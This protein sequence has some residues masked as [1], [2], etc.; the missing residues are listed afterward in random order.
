MLAVADH[1]IDSFNS[2]SLEFGCMDGLNTFLLLGGRL[3]KSF[4]VFKETRW[5]VDSHLEATLKDDYYD[6]YDDDVK[7]LIKQPPKKQLDYGVDWKFS[8]LNKSRRLGLYR[9][10]IKINPL[11]PRFDLENATLNTIWAPNLYWSNNLSLTLKV[12]K[13]LLTVEGKIF[14]ILPDILLTKYMIYKHANSLNESWISLL[15]RGRFSNVIKSGKTFDGWNQYF[16]SHELTVAQH[17]MFLP[18]YVAQFYEIGL[19][20]MFSVMLN[21]YKRI[22][23]RSQK[24]LASL[25]SEWLDRVT[26]LLGPLLSTDSHD[27]SEMQ[28]QWHFFELVRASP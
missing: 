14:T 16:Q 12:L 7:I 20:P 21:A 17:K 10:L 18:T 2:P 8:H 4:D 23:S 5:S 6:E 9:S 28:N 27:E 25:K 26:Y 19:R 24:D 1:S 13:S 15:D 3:D 22:D 11:A